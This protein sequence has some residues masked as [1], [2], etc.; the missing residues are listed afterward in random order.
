M[1]RTRRESRG[2]PAPLDEALTSRMPAGPLPPGPRANAWDRV[3]AVADE[4]HRGVSELVDAL[5]HP[6]STTGMPTARPP[7]S[8][9]APSPRPERAIR[10]RPT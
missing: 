10:C 1:D 8:V 7:A 6:G 9:G 5:W 2:L 3:G 4:P